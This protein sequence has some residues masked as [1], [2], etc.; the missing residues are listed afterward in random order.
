[1]S[2][3]V[4]RQWQYQGN[5][6]DK[7]WLDGKP[8]FLAVDVISQ[9]VEQASPNGQPTPAIAALPS[10]MRTGAQMLSAISQQQLLAAVTNSPTVVANAFEEKLRAIINNIWALSMTTSASLRRHLL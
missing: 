1:M 8:S 5:A 10:T 3:R 4:H 2:P 6:L 9:A 7:I